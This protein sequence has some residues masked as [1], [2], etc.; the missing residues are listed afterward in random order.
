MTFS[1]VKSDSRE[2][3]LAAQMTSKDNDN[4]SVFVVIMPLATIYFIKLCPIIMGL[5]NL[6]Q[7]HCK[8]RGDAGLTLV[9]ENIKNYTTNLLYSK[10]NTAKI[11]QNVIVGSSCN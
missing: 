4:Q 9:R 10:S 5:F 8:T 6:S 11:I 7:Q 3:V 2:E 1:V